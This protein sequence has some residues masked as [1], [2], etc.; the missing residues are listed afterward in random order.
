MWRHCGVFIAAIEISDEGL[1]YILGSCFNNAQTLCKLQPRV[2][3]GVSYVTASASKQLGA[4]AG[5]PCLP[6][7][8]IRP[9][10]LGHSQS[11][12]V[13]RNVEFLKSQV[14]TV[15]LRSKTLLYDQACLWVD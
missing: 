7:I 10:G 13:T 2:T 8:V 3:S 15:N 12:I 6:H 11:D 4:I 9:P 5:L 14:I 1:R